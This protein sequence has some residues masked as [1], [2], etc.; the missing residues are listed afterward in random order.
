M[1]GDD[2][3]MSRCWRWRL[4]EVRGPAGLQGLERAQRCGLWEFGTGT[5]FRFK[6]IYTYV[7]R[8]FVVQVWETNVKRENNEFG[9]HNDGAST[10]RSRRK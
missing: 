6:G 3:R 10:C 8:D 9:K 5:R 7:A 2:G 4:F 1:I